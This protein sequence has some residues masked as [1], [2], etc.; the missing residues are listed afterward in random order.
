MFL[1][2]ARCSRSGCSFLITSSTPLATLPEIGGLLLTACPTVTALVA[3]FAGQLSDRFGT[4][5][6]SSW[7][8]ALEAVGLW[9][10]SRLGV[11]F[12]AVSVIFTL[13]LVGL[14]LGLFQAPNM[15]FVMGYDPPR[16]AGSRG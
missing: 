4:T 5:R 16:A 12:G 3:P 7:G 6:L 14:G 11:Q 2:T 9:S 8:L 15:S 13:A 1:R 10:I